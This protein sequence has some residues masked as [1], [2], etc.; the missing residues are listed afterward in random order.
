MR[1]T[2]VKPGTFL[3]A[4]LQLFFFLFW[5][6]PNSYAS[7]TITVNGLANGASMA[8]G[9]PFTWNIGGL[10]NGAVVYNELWVDVN[11]NGVIDVG[12]DFLFV[13][14]PQRD[15]DPGSDGP[16]DDD[17]I[18]NGIIT[19]TIAGMYFPVSNYVFKVKSG[20]DSATS[21][22]QETAMSAPTYSVSGR[23][24]Q[25]GVGKAN[26]AVAVQTDNNGEFYA[27]TTAT[28]YY[29]V[30]T[31]L[32]AGTNVNVRIP[33]DAFNSQLMGLIVTPGEVQFNLSGNLF[34]VNFTVRTGTVVT[35][36]VVDAQ[37][38]PIADMQVQIYPDDGGNG[39]DGRSDGNGRYFISVDVGNYVVQ[40]GSNEDPKG[41]IKTYYNQKHVGWMTDL[42]QVASGVDTVRNINATLHRGGLIMG[43]FIK[44]GVPVRGN[45]TVFDYNNPGNA[46]YET[47]HD[48]TNPYYYLIVPP[49]TYSVQF[50]L[51]NGQSQCY[52][53]QTWFSPGNSVTVTSISDTAKNIDVNFSTLPKVYQF[54]GWGDWNNPGNWQNNQLPPATLPKGDYIIINGGQCTLNGS[55]TISIGAYLVVRPGATLQ[56]NGNLIR[57]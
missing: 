27:F 49:G 22:Y 34:N 2:M 26:V 7:I 54:L 1:T 18:A 56:V 25:G 53:N 8:Q 50:N 21:S 29:T 51:E 35:G 33:V 47:W 11:S 17:A 5:A 28:G 45:I 44:D 14:F 57:Q 20:T 9:A 23:V 48:N 43:T 32:V 6:K 39:Y 30:N 38:N 12:T 13:G 24:T 40:F 3:L 16:G 42:V 4:V 10:Q 46:L 15:G 19:T 52:Y 41:Y 36:R 31:N 37:S 55:Q